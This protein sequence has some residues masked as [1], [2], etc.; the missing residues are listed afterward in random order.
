MLVR[1]HLL[2]LIGKD[3]VYPTNRHVI[4]AFRQATGQATP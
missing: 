4:T 2:G 3:R 1:Y